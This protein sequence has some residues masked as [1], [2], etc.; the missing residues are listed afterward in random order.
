MNAWYISHTVTSQL[1]AETRW[2][3]I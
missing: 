2:P 3:V 1:Y